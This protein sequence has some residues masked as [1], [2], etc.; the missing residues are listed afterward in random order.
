VNHPGFDLQVLLMLKEATG[1]RDESQREIFSNPRHP[2][3]SDP[4]PPSDPVRFP[5]ARDPR[6]LIS[7]MVRDGRTRF[8]PVDQCG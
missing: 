4:L 8:P 5:G 7:R 6:L 2:D 1:N 3:T